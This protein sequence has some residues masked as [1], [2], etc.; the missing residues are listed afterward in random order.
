MYVMWTLK[1]LAALLNI[2]GGAAKIK[3]HILAKV[4]AALPAKA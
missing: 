3:C 4:E 2:V 1:I